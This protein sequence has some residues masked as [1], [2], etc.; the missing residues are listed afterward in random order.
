MD[1]NSLIIFKKIADLGGITKAAKGLGLPKSAISQRLSRLEEALGGRL[2]H[3]TTRNITLTEFGE[4]MYR[5]AA[6]IAEQR[7]MMLDFANSTTEAATGLIRMTSPPD[8][9]AHLISTALK[10]FMSEHPDIRVELDLSTRFV[11]LASEGIDLAIRATAR[12]LDDS[13]LVAKKIHESKIG[14][15]ASK[16]YF[17]GVNPPSSLDGLKDHRMVCF[18]VTPGAKEQTLKLRRNDTSLSTITIRPQFTANNYQGA[19]AAIK[20]GI[21]IGLLPEDLARHDISIGALVPVLPE[22]S[23]GPAEFYVV[24]P[25]RKFLPTRIKLLVQFLEKWGIRG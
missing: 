12:G 21:G 11:D 7:D 4:T 19:Y 5:H 23:S 3:R 13:T 8:L 18:S 24:Y 22:W 6:L 25:S 20:A 14:L 17:L 15:F 9:G 2:F 10:R 16:E 1:L